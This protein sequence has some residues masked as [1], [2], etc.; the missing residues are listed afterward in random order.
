MSV[1]PYRDFSG[2]ALVAM[3]SWRYRY[4]RI[5]DYSGPSRGGLR[6]ITSP[7]SY[8]SSSQ[9]LNDREGDR[10]GDG[11]RNKQVAC[12]SHLFVFTPRSPMAIHVVLQVSNS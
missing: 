12:D 2:S 6:A 1:V 11:E 9:N 3:A 7:V 4:F 8:V 5:V 10:N